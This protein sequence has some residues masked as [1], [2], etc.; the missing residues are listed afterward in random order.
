MRNTLIF[1]SVYRNIILI[2]YSKLSQHWKGPRRSSS[3]TF[4]EYTNYPYILPGTV[5]WDHLASAYPTP[6]RHSLLSLTFSVSPK[7]W[8]N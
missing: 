4:T 5:D 3:S 6:I 1:T 2:T 8:E 7:S